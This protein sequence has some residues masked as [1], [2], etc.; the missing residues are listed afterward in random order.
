MEEL[1]AFYELKKNK[2]KL[3]RKSTFKCLDVEEAIYLCVE[4]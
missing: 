3:K 1:N 2:L 4:G